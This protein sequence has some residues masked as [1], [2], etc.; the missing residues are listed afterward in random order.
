MAPPPAKARSEER[1]GG[2]EG[3]GDCTSWSAPVVEIKKKMR[4]DNIDRKERVGEKKETA[5]VKTQEGL[6]RETFPKQGGS[7]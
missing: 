6:K 7:H 5:E 2:K 3:R 1:R 4:R